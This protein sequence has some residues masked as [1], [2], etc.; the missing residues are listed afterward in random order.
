MAQDKDRRTERPTGRQVRR[1]HEKGN[2]ARS[3]D[4]GHTATL[5]VFLGWSLLFGGAF[6]LG[7]CEML[8]HGLQRAGRSNADSGLL[9]ALIAS[10]WGGMA[11]VGPLVLALAAASFAAQVLQVGFTIKKNPLEFD[12][13]RLNPI[14]GLSQLITKHKLVQAAKALIKVVAYCGLA[15]LVVLPEWPQLVGLSLSTPADIFSS[16]CAIAFRVL[17]RALLVSLLIAAADWALSYRMWYRELYMT[18][19]EVKDEHRE[20]EGDPTTRGRIRSKMRDAFRRRMMA[21]VKTADVVVTNP[22]HVA[23]AL[24]YERVK[25]QAPV[26]VAKGRG[27]IAQRIR[28]EAQLHRIPLLEDPPLARTL[29]KL[30]P[31][32]LPIPPSLYKAVAEVFAYVIGRRR[33]QYRYHHEVEALTRRGSARL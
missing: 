15:L 29:E 32:G 16:T 24:R 28:E 8:R 30:C 1:A 13:R 11:L 9:D 18:K 23:V 10:A 17:I 31:L 6:T 22:T 3:S 5:A 12:L 7:L 19:Q 20:S 26:V 21:A 2:F 27:F 33:G 25:H 4:L 14:R